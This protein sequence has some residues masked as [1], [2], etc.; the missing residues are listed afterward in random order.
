[1]PRLAGPFQRVPSHQASHRLLSVPF[2]NTYWCPCAST[3]ALGSEPS[4]PMPR[5]A[6]PFQ[7]VPSQQAS[8]RLSSVPFQNTY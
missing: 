1:M 6:G 5:L 7:R 3:P 4:G 2:Q 8:H